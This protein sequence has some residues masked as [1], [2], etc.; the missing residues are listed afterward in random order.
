M[1]SDL[2][3]QVLRSGGRFYRERKVSLDQDL[4]DGI[5]GARGQIL[6]PSSNWFIPYYADVGTGDCNLTWQAMLGLGYRFDW[7]HVTLA[8]R[9]LGYDFNKDN[10]DLTLYGPGLGVG[11]RW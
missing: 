8:Y 1:S 4:W 7:G 3:I 5:V 10:T 2:E 9:A 11:F 6:F